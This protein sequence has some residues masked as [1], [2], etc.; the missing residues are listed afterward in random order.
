MTSGVPGNEE[1]GDREEPILIT[2]DMLAPRRAPRPTDRRVDFERGMRWLP[3]L[4]V[5]LIVANIAVFVWEVVAGVF[6]GPKV[7]ID[8]G[9]ALANHTDPLMAGALIRER[10]LAGE[11][12]RM[13]TATFLHG[14]PDHLIGNMIALFIV[15][16][17]CEHAFGAAKTAVI[18][19]GSALAGTAFSLATGPGPSVGA[20]GAIFG[21]LMAVVV[22]LYRNQKYFFVRDKRIGFVLA[23]WAAWQLFIGFM[24]PFIDNFAH[25]GGM[26]GGALAALLLTPTLTTRETLIRTV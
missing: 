12:W 10:V 23:A 14:S 9:V 4:I 7:A 25:L 17:A 3:P 18:Y 8:S 13:I 20:S 6:L 11:W 5:A 26:T 22:M 1:R 21:V 15:G 24:S 16:M 2:P 19:F